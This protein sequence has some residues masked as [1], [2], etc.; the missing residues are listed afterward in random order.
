[1]LNFE[2][3]RTVSAIGNL[4]AESDMSDGSDRLDRSDE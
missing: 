3:G 1:M 4:S 2:F